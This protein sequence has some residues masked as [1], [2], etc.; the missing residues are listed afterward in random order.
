MQAILAFL[1]EMVKAEDMNNKSERNPGKSARKFAR[2]CRSE[3]NA[4]CIYY[5][6][7]IIRCSYRGEMK[8]YIPFWR[9]AN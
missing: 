8:D 7:S 6:S 3:T 4:G 9:E 2:G 1:K 5:K